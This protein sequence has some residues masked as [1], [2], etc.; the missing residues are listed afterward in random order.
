MNRIEKLENGT[1]KLTCENGQTFMCRRWEEVKK[2]KRMWHICPPKE[3]VAI[4]GRS[5][6]RESYFD[7][8]NIYEF[9]TK[10]EHREGLGNGGWKSRLTEEEL[11]EY[12][13]LEKRMEELKNI[14]MARPVKELT[15]EE[16]LLR[17]IA[18]REKLLAELRA[19]KNN[20]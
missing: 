4:C 15:E 11:E 17:E 5:Y 16:K 20:Q 13:S 3:A 9:E 8:S 14:A 1:Y 19:K 2:D 10:T 18:K 12:Q 7:N 6:I